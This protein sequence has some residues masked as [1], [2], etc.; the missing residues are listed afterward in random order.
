MEQR[1]AT[2]KNLLRITDPY[3]Y[4][5]RMTYPPERETN[6]F[7]DNG[8]GRGFIDVYDTTGKT[9]YDFKFGKTARMSKSQY[10]KYSSSFP[11]ASIVIIKRQ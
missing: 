1:T 10:Y 2:I 4:Y 11:D 3:I 9:I 8:Y 7:F 5:R 6:Y